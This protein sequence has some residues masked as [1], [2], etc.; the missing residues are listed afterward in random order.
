MRRLGQPKFLGRWVN[1]NGHSEFL[2]VGVSKSYI[3]IF[4]CDEIFKFTKE[5]A[6]IVY[7]SNHLRLV[8]EYFPLNSLCLCQGFMVNINGEEIRW[9][10][11]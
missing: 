1:I 6:E 4:F 8:D 9:F 5:R 3:F 7:G 10:K 2:C 11:K